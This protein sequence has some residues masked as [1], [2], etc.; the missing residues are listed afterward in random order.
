M[1]CVSYSTES[2]SGLS[3]NNGGEH[4]DRCQKF[5]NSSLR[6]VPKI[7]AN[8]PLVTMD[9]MLPCQRSSSIFS[10]GV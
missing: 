4:H 3:K 7:P 1:D 2:R 8:T 10:L 9:G 6:K 5:L